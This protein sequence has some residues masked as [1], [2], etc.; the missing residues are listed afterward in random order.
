MWKA[1]DYRIRG[2]IRAIIGH[3]LQS[4]GV[5]VG[6]AARTVG[7]SAQSVR[8]WE[9][10]GLVTPLRTAG[11]HRVF[12]AR[13]VDRLHEIKRLRTVEGLN[14][15]A[16]RQRLGNDPEQE[17]A[18]PGEHARE[19]EALGARFRRLRV[20]QHKSVAEV[21]EGTG[22]SPSFISTVERGESGMS[23]AL[24]ACWPP[25]TG[26]KTFGCSTASR[27]SPDRWCGA[28]SGRR[29]CGPVGWSSRI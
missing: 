21:A 6:V 15:A 4:V 18:E 9:R 20:S 11:G 3:V 12:R 2:A 13:D 16:I 22:L 14:V 26:S 29:W 1:A 24:C 25:I 7:V 19:Q 5:S 28:R 23:L 8:A 10:A 27:V 17:V